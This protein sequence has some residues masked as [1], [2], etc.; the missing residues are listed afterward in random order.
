MVNLNNNQIN[1]RE[2]YQEVDDLLRSGRVSEAKD[3]L[4]ELTL[5][6]VPRANRE[7]MA[8]LF[9]RVGLFDSGIRLL[10]P[11]IHAQTTQPPASSREKITY[12]MLLIK[13]GALDE[14]HRILDSLKDQLPEVHLCRGFALQANWDYANAATQLEL[15]IEQTDTTPYEIAIAKVN[16]LSCLISSNQHAKANALIDSLFVEFKN[17]GWSLLHKN[18]QELS[19]QLAASRSDLHTARMELQIA[20]RS[21]FRDDSLWDFLIAK[22]TAFVDLRI[23]PGDPEAR[24]KLEEVRQRAIEIPHWETV[25]ECD[26]ILGVVTKDSN[27]LKKVY[28]GT[29]Y[30]AYRDRLKAECPWLEVSTSTYVHG[31]GTRVFDLKTGAC[32][33]D[34]KLSLKTGSAL[35]RCLLALCSDLYRPVFTGQLYSRVFP[36]EHYDPVTSHNRIASVIGRLRAWLKENNVAI[37]IRLDDRFANLVWNHD[38]DFAVSYSD[39][40]EATALSLTKEELQLNRLREAVLDREFAL[41][42]LMAI[43]EISKPT[44][45]KLTNEALGQGL[46]S[47]HGTARYVVYKFGQ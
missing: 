13:I 44:A 29:P 35:H 37:E 5:K 41:S 10:S 11:I 25:R 46:I 45:L 38:T 7:R 26:R 9:N 28:F 1:W 3:K 42:E 22:G 4:Q 47:R 30:S 6:N 12:A 16:L 40:Q 18:L 21:F 27:L 23:N 24:Q 34:E 8:Y 36:Q 15:F 43:L 33:Q 17:Q 39:H 20:K 32:A 14:T 19:S 31:S 2:L